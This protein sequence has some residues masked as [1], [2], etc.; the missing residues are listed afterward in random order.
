MSLK[1]RNPN[2]VSAL[3]SCEEEHA[4]DDEPPSTEPEQPQISEVPLYRKK[5]STL[6]QEETIRL[7]DQSKEFYQKYFPGT[8]EK[9]WRSW[10]WQI[11][12]SFTSLNHLNSIIHL[13]DDESFKSGNNQDALPIRITPYYASLIDPLDDMQPIRKSVIPIQAEYIVCSGEHSDPLCEKA[14][15]PVPNIVHRYPDRVL[16]LATA[17]CSTYCRYCT[18]SH[19]VAK[20]DKIRPG[21][22]AMEEALNYI[23]ANSQIRDVLISGGDPLTLSDD[24]LDYLLA[25]LRA[26]PHVEFVRIGTKVP[27][28]L[29]QR[30]TRKLASILKKY[31]P[32]FISIHFTHP[33]EITPEVREACG[34]LANAGIPL[35]SQTVLL[36]DINDNTETMKKLMQQLLTIRVRPYYLYQCDPILGSEHF[37][38]PVAKGIEIMQGIIGHTTGYARPTY[39]IDAPGGGGK[40]PIVPP[41]MLGRK[42]NDIIMTNYKNGVFHYPDVVADC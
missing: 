34:R 9:E 20:R 11:K 35:G 24:Y 37:R 23:A 15:S 4:G 39:V 10:R 40:I 19:M 2:F 7:S 22:S 6:P 30:I 38:T 32:L 18:R 13:S 27:V 25:R 28:V 17:F 5:P 29:P 12:N 31:H 41:Y 14:D 36:K 3:P 33:D 42:N 1:Y 21:T 8:T 16:L 26:I